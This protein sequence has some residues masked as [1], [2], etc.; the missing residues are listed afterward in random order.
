[1]RRRSFLGSLGVTILPVT[2]GCLTSLEDRLDTSL[3]LGWFGGQNFDIDSHRFDFKVILD[4]TEVHNSSHEI[5]GR[6]GSYVHGVT[7]ECSWG[8]THGEYIVSARVDDGEWKER[9]LSDI[10]DYWADDVDCAIAEAE[11]HS[12]EL[13]FQLERACDVEFGE[14]CS[15]TKNETTEST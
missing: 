4:G 6:E 1:M 9:P 13:V 10:E 3:Q 7:V 11:Y 12:D 2:A 15:F 8:S 5:P 14:K